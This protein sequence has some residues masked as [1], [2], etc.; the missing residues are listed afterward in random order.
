MIFR[1]DKKHEKKSPLFGKLMS[2]YTDLNYGMTQPH[3]V[4]I[5]RVQLRQDQFPNYK[6]TFI[7]INEFLLILI[8]YAKYRDKSIILSQR[9]RKEEE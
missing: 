4:Y 7:I 8:T 5:Y 3:N 1:R 6:L 2:Y 9:K